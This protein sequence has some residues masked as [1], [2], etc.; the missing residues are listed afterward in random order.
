MV[1]PIQTRTSTVTLTAGPSVVT[2][3]PPATTASSTTTV[4]VAGPS[5]SNPR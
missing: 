4:K 1:A 2:F 5:E 3:T